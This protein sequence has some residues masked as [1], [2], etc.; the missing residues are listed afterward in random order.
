M[1]HT[2]EYRPLPLRYIAPE[3][4]SDNFGKVDNEDTYA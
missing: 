2:V 4:R 1:F 3:A